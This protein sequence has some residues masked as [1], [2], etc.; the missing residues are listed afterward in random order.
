MIGRV[1]VASRRW[2]GRVI[3]SRS[4]VTAIE[5]GLIAASIA[6]A[7]LAIM[8]LLGGDMANMFSSVSE[9]VGNANGS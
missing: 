2:S 4:G 6:V 9:A 7:F 5:Y 1:L 8:V 3:R